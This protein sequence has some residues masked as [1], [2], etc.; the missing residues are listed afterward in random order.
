MLKKLSVL[1][2]YA[3]IF[4]LLIFWA[5]FAYYT[6]N[7]LIQSQSHYAKVINL[8]GKQ[9]MLSQKIVLSLQMHQKTDKQQYLQEAKKLLKTFQDD[10]AFIVSNLQSQ[11]SNELY[12]HTGGINDTVSDY[13]NLVKQYFQN[14]KEASVTQVYALSQVLLPKL[15]DAVSVFQKESEQKTR[16]LQ[17]RELLIYMATVLTIL[18]EAHFFARPVIEKIKMKFGEYKRRLDSQYK[19]LLL[20]SKVFTNANDAIIIT[21][22]HSKILDV[23]PAFERVTGYGKEEVLGKTPGILKS[24]RHKQSFYEGMWQ[25]LQKAG[26]FSSEIVN[27]TKGGKEYIQQSDIF[28]IY[29]ENKQVRY[30][31]GILSDITYKYETKRQLSF[32]ANYDSLTKLPNRNLMY[33]IAQ[34]AIEKADRQKQ[35]VAFLY[36]DLDDFKTVNDALGHSYGDRLL[37]DM[38]SQLRTNLRKSDTLCRVGGDE[39]I[40]I[41]E[42]IGDTS[43]V[44]T[45]AKR[46][47]QILAKPFML[48]N[49]DFELSGSM[50]ISIYPN[51]ADD[52]DTIVKYADMAMFRAK[53]LG[54]NSFSY[55][56]EKLHKNLLKKLA[57]EA[58]MKQALQ[59]DEFIIYLQPKIDPYSRR[60]YS[61]EALVRWQKEGRLVPP[62]EFIPIAEQSD[63]ILHIGQAVYEK[64]V[65]TLQSWDDTPYGH[66][67]IS[68]NISPKQIFHTQ[69]LDSIE[70]LDEKIASRLIFEITEHSLVDSFDMM[71]K[72]INRCNK[73]GI[74][75]AIDDFGTGYSSLMYLKKLPLDYIK[76]D[77]EFLVDIFENTE[78]DVIV[79]TIISMAQNLGVKSIVE[80]VETRQ[81]A[82]YMQRLGA[83]ILQGFYYA[84][85]LDTQQ[86]TVFITGFDQKS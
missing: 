69:L 81:Q 72:F 49:I 23:N 86:C 78:D 13:T 70:S 57:F 68:V 42:D 14:P 29:D 66:L 79:K 28:A 19:S 53:E 48:K 21:D 33:E 64:V 18:F 61:L 73:L 26:R 8:S 83:D 85:P 52:I 59:N 34:K 80:G 17:N 24:N 56:D 22:A 10:Y 46:V 51:D 20:Q 6:M 2:S 60:V 11:R 38:V 44:E 16:Q 4:A 35:K 25:Q 50:G 39:F 9:R 32:L 58:D 45:F 77:K 36:L 41:L 76:I 40:F 54:K 84:K 62:G 65:A 27:K 1:Q 31:V 30:Y 67:P 55:Y 43:Y 37:I 75:T 5:S 3:I 47:L 71:T 82:E 15:D 63:L 7:S 74:Q 12:F